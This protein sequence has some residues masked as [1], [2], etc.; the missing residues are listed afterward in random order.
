MLIIIILICVYEKAQ[1]TVS[2]VSR[3]ASFY[4]LFGMP[5]FWYDTTFPA[6]LVF[7]SP[8]EIGFIKDFNN[9]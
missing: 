7:F 6:I 8:F 9:K 2:L 1:Q 3:L 4:L 5:V